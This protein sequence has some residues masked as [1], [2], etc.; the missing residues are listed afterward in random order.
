MSSGLYELLAVYLVFSLRDFRNVYN[1]ST[2]SAVLSMATSKDGRLV[3]LGM[4]S[5][6]SVHVRTPKKE[7]VRAIALTDRM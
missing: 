3:A 2:P 1:F 5:L 6:L 7:A 4:A